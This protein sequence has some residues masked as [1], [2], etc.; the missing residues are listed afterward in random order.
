M[1]MDGTTP[2]RDLPMDVVID[3][4]L[5]RLPVKTLIRFTSVCKF[6]YS[7]IRNP[8]FI[9]THINRSIYNYILFMPLRNRWEG[10]F[11]VICD[12]SFVEHAKLEIPF[13]SEYGI[14][15]IVGSCNGLLCLTDEY[16]DAFGRDLYLWNPSVRKYKT[17][18][19]SS[20]I[21]FDDCLKNYSVFGFGFHKCANDYRVV[22]IIYFGDDANNFFGKVPPEVEVYSLSTDSW[23]RVGAAVPCEVHSFSDS[24]AFV[25]GAVH[26][27]AY[28]SAEDVVMSFDLNDEVFR[29]VMLPDNL[30][31][32]VG[33]IVSLMDFKGSLSL[34]VFS[35]EMPSVS[36]RCYIWLL[37]EY[38][39]VKSWTKQFTIVPQ[40]TVEFP[41]GC[42][43]SG[44]VIFQT[45]GQLFSFDVENQQF[46]DLGTSWEPYAVD[47]MFM[48]SLVLLEGGNVA[49]G[50]AMSVGGM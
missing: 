26:W 32:G 14:V 41:L 34:F 3:D 49:F 8:K 19:S 25:D 13:C 29:E 17:I 37:R 46:K 1:L 38:G 12:K 40:D 10:F 43:K 31:D 28:S 23:K 18:F 5:S 21:E 22:R 36:K 27:L 47:A 24:L 50:Q 9:T 39:A 30:L 33:Q 35:P 11:S 45:G 16:V 44:K 6:W 48:E 7:L 2:C 42:T 4:I 15:R 20:V